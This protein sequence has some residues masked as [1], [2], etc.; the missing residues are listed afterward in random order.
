MEENA[1]YGNRSSAQLVARVAELESFLAAMKQEAASQVGLDYSWAGNLGHW[2]W[3]VKANSVEFSPQKTA[4]LGFSEQDLPGSVAFQF[5]TDRIH[6][7]DYDRVM[8]NMRSHLQHKTQ[9]YECEYRIRHR[10]GSYRWFYD[11]G[12][13]TQV[14]EQNRPILVTGIVFDISA[15]K[16]NEEKLER[17]AKEMSL[18]VR[19]LNFAHDGLIPFPEL[20]PLIVEIIPEGW[21]WPERTAARIRFMGAEYATE[22][23]RTSTRMLT[24]GIHSFGNIVGGIEVSLL[25]SAPSEVAFL[26]EE[27]NLLLTLSR[28]ISRLAERDESHDTLKKSE[29]KLRQYLDSAPDSIFIVDEEGRYREVNPAASSLLGYSEQDLLS[30]TISDILPPESAME[31]L[32]SFIETKETGR[33]S[34]ETT[35]RRKDGEKLAVALDS[36]ALPDGRYMGFCRDI[37]AQKRAESQHNLYFRAV[38][39]IDQAII[40]TDTNGRITEVNRAFS[41][42][43]GYSRDE[44]VGM[45]PRF[46]NP[47]PE[48]YTNLGYSMEEYRAIFDGLWSAIADPSRGS[49]EGIVVNRQ[50]N[51]SLVWANLVVNAIYDENHRVQHLIGLPIDISE[52]RRRANLGSID[53]Y[54]A[55]TELAALRD[56]ET[57]NHV[58]RVGIFAKHLAKA[59]DMPE[60]YCD[61]IAI[62]APMHDIGKVGILDSILLA[63]RRLTSAERAEMEKHTVL[64]YN[65]VKG[66]KELDLV[67]AITLHHHERFDGTGYPTGLAGENIPLSARIT[68]IADVYDALRSERPYKHGWTHEDAVTEIRS[69]AGN[70]YD[71]RIVECFSQLRS[72]FSCIFEELR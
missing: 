48:A 10:D 14:D 66:K 50:K 25:E 8:E 32:R 55:I 56:N 42:L 64:G 12:K 43:Y 5:F 65:I 40:V 4:A 19:V 18:L 31:G 60:K 52:S 59:L 27:K 11:R 69:H 34:I 54:T 49:W 20:L 33:S 2:Y 38:E 21:Q 72:A 45:N 58:R 46:L 67:A 17:H 47:G 28:F 62:F 53:L 36:R 29:A 71:P 15:R 41:E 23:F 44:V 61:D 68:T 70:Y 3:N 35:L 30:M 37:S 63:E 6:T 24:E 26:P 1:N 57:G 22:G 51:G 13:V 16:A 7:D 9:V 39:A